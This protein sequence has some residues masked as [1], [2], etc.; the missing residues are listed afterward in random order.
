MSSR[1]RSW[2]RSRKTSARSSS[3]R[4]GRSSACSRP[5]R[6]RSGASIRTGQTRRVVCARTSRSS[7]ADRNRAF[8]AAAGISADPHEVTPPAGLF[9]VAYLR[10]EPVGC[11]AVK[12]HPGRPSEIK[13]MWVAESA[14]GL[15][16][17]RRLLAALEAD[18]AASGATMAR[19]ETNK[20][21]V[22][23]IALY[24]SAGSSRCRRSATSRSRTTGSKAAAARPTIL[25]TCEPCN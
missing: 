12:H 9:L 8:D 19:L 11:G 4:C 15:G 24:R 10:D 16:I 13:R 1:S 17:A 7:T 25:T 23:A 22:E 2:P 5:A 20:A 21:L 18:A 6:S 14:R 3:P